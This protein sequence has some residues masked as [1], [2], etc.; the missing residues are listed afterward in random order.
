MFFQGGKTRLDGTNSRLKFAVRVPINCA[1]FIFYYLLLKV[2]VG[3]QGET[4]GLLKNHFVIAEKKKLKQKFP[5][6]SDCNCFILLQPV[7][8]LSRAI[9]L[10]FSC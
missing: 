7:F 1:C 6:M 9:F 3:T 5:Q 8:R 4:I 10:S 2:F